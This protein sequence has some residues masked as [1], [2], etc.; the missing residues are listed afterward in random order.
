M[1]T[2]E[3]I[4]KLRLFINTAKRM[5]QGMKMPKNIEKIVDGIC[6]EYEKKY[7]Q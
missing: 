2:K 1:T 7:N 6:E 5:E 3:D 4:K